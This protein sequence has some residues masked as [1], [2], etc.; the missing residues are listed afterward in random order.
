MMSQAGCSRAAEIMKVIWSIL[1][2]LMEYLTHKRECWSEH[3]NFIGSHFT[4]VK[5]A[6]QSNIIHDEHLLCLSFCLSLVSVQLSSL[7]LLLNA[8]VLLLCFCSFPLRSGEDDHLINLSLYQD[9]M[10]LVV[11]NNTVWDLYFLPRQ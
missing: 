7:Q 6:A 10:Y 3:R 9:K 8:L 2:C 4:L 5:A 1:S 11:P